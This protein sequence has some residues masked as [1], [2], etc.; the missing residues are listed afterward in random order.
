MMMLP[1]VCGLDRA[2]RS[3]RLDITEGF[4]FFSFNSKEYKSSPHVRVSI[5]Q[6]FGTIFPI[7]E[8]HLTEG[9]SEKL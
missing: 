5:L 1:T 8:Q 9:K 2:L 7:Q 4:F 6:A 3:Y